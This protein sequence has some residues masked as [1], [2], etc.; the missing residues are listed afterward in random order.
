M[1]KPFHIHED[2]RQSNTL[3][4]AFYNSPEVFA[5]VR[6]KIFA[7]T[8][9]YAADTTHL[10]EPLSVYPCTLLP[11]VL[12]E[13]LVFT[14]DATGTLHCL[15]NVCT[16]R[17]KIV[18]E[19]PGQSRLLSC[20]YH[21]RCFHLNGA[22]KSM[23]EFRETAN[24]PTPMDDLAKIPFAEWMGM[25]FVSLDPKNHFEEMT[26]PIRERIGWLPL[27]TLRLAPQDSKD[28]FVEANWA[29]Y[30]DNYLEG[31]HI[32]FVHPALNQALDFRSYEYE[33]FDYCNLQVGIAK[34]GEPCFDLPP[35]APDYGKQV[36][37]YYFWLFPNLMLNFYPWGLSMNVV[38][39]L[40]HRR[41]AIRYRTLYFGDTTFHREVNRIDQTEL[42]D[43]AV[44]ESVQQGLQSRFYQHGRF[45]PTQEQGVHHFHRLVASFL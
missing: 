38:E 13:P 3:P 36:Y 25:L 8:W 33:I 29:L 14:K 21:G 1:T 24:F 6:E 4:G 16:H 28:Y 10:R 19:Q 31:F 40:S 12:N 11:E 37:A 39:P 22:F 35:G 18:I 32:P 5:Q 43:D 27:D 34:Q 30:C 15:S 45:S 44:V 17:G 42:E 20:G 23:P 26:R 9:L 41:T 2:I 7:R